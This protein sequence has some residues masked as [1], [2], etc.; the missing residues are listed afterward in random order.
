MKVIMVLILL[1]LVMVVVLLVLVYVGNEGGWYLLKFNLQLN[2][3]GGVMVLVVDMQQNYNNKVSNFGMLNNV[4]VSGLIKNVLGNVGVNVVV[5]D[6]NQQV[7]VVVLV[8]VDVSFVFGIVIV[9]ISVLQSGYGNMLNNYFNFNIVLLS[10]LVNN[11]L[12]NLGVNVVVGN[13]NQQKNDLVVVV[14]NGQYSIVG[15]VVLQIF[16]GNIIVN[17]VNYVYGGIYVL[18]KLN[19]DGSYKGI[20]DQ[21][22]DVYFDIWEGQIYLG[23]SNIGYIDVDSQVQGVKDLNYDGGV[24]VFK[25]KGDVDLKGMVFGFILVIVG[26]KILVINNVSLSNLLQNVLGNVGV[27]IV[28][29]GGNQQ[30]NFL[31]IVVGC[32]SCLVGGESFGF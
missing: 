21:I 7:N 22:G 15:S 14:F 19:V 27:N 23:G 10:N 1:V 28:V 6:N 13:F 32:S 26:F 8:S 18:L 2:N 29:G 12:G 3:K 30:S 20:F 5:G 17:S 16:I 4:L 24:F 31:F 25:E 11:V 9:S